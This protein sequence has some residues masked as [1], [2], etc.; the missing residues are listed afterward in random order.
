MDDTD[1]GDGSDRRG[2]TLRTVVGMGGVAEHG[3]A[4]QHPKTYCKSL[5]IKKSSKHP[6]GVLAVVVPSV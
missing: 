3:A 5:S 6:I 4:A 1:A 2:E